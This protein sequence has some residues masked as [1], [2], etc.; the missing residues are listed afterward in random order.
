MDTAKEALFRAMLNHGWFIKSDGDVE[1]PLGYFGYVNNEQN[2]LRSIY[3]AFEDTVKA[4]GEPDDEDVVGNFFAYI[5]SNGTIHI[6]RYDKLDD[7]KRQFEWHIIEYGEW[8]E[9]Q[10]A[11]A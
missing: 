10:E 4:Y 3:D 9:R 6:Y 5:N 1:C 7:A 11:N 8:C 2:E